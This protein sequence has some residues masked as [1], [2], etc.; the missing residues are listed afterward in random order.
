MGGPHQDTLCQELRPAPVL[1]VGDAELYHEE[2]QG[3]GAL[4]L[5]PEPER[6]ARLWP[7]P[8]TSGVCR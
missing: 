3:L 7:S 8:L 4:A 6:R 1:W 5:S 2:N